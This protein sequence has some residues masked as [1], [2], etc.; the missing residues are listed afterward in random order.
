MTG[1]ESKR[2]AAQAK[3]DEDDDTQVYGDALT[4]AYQS[5]FFDGKKTAQ[6][7][8]EFIGRLNLGAMINTS[9]SLEYD[10]WDVE[11]SAKRIDALQERLVGCDPVTLDIYITPPAA[12]P[13]QEFDVLAPHPKPTQAQLAYLPPSPDFYAPPQ[14]EW[15]GLTEDELVQIGVATGLERAAVEMISNKLKERNA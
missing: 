12:Q 9:E 15:V 11:L 10:D 3:L 13:E 2:A 1:Y 4:I 14:R 6:P 7:A 8:Q 5:G